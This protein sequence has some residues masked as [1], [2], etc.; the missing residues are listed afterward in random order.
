[1]ALKKE[2]REQIS[3][4]VN[5]HADSM[6]ACAVCGHKAWTLADGMLTLP[7]RDSLDVLNSGDR[8][9][10]SAAIVCDNC[11]NTHLLN[12]LVLGLGHLLEESSLP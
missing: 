4:A 6:R 1:M 10:P 7:V 3:Q 11:G 9:L 8:V 12:L 5:A 2:A